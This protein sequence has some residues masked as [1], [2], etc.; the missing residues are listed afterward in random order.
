MA[1]LVENLS[2]SLPVFVYDL[3]GRICPGGVFL[4]AVVVGEEPSLQLTHTFGDAGSFLVLVGGSFVAG[5]LLNALG[6]LMFDVPLQIVSR[7]LPEAREL[8]PN[9][10]W[11]ELDRIDATSERHGALLFKM[12]A[13]ATL[14]QNL[15]AAFLA[16]V[17]LRS[18]GYL[19][20]APALI[21]RHRP[22]TWILGLLILGTAVHRTAVIFRRLR[23]IRNVL[24]LK[25]ANKHSQVKRH[26]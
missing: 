24:H 12:E 19:M 2:K 22:L 13:E 18:C 11:D 25:P 7:I 5:I 8:A 9:L 16:L 17:I 6:A 20:N 3:V 4:I 1:E 10:L 15:F 23:S 14:C 21:D 26:S